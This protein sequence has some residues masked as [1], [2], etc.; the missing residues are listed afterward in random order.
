MT[1]RV[2]LPLPDDFHLHLRDG[3]MLR[4]VLPDTARSFGR[5]IVMPNLVPPV[6]ALEDAAAYRARILA[7]LPEGLSFEPLMTLYLTDATSPAEVRRAQDS[8]IVHGVKL[9]PAHATTNSAHG[10]TRIEALDAV[11]DAMA[12]VSLPLLV[13]GEQLGPSIDV[14]DREKAFLDNVLDPLARR[15][16]DLRI[17]LEHVTTREGIDW[18]LEGGD[19][20]AGTLTAHHLLLDRNDLFAGGLRPHHY[21]LPVV[22]RRE[23]KEALRK[24]ACSGHPRVFLGTDSAPHP[25]RAKEAPKCCA[26][27]YT[28]PTALAL[29]AR[30]FDEEDALEHLPAFAA[31][32]GR[33]FYGLDPNPGWVALERSERPV[34]APPVLEVEPGVEVLP[35]HPDDGLHWRQV[36]GP[37]AS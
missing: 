33:R 35:F 4:A 17:V 24:A 18:V 8:G 14:F 7:A 12:E 11:F 37:S 6:V 9:Y 5:A 21:C 27:L 25:I 1:D 3:A 16:P 10:V 28:A 20:I 19:R 26:G 13:H 2:E 32:N 30:V 23:H 31:L 29:Y 36:S 15:H 22:K 34:P